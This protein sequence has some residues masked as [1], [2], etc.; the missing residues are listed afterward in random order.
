MS[1]R[2]NERTEIRQK[3]YKASV[4]ADQGRRRR[5]NITVGIRKSDRD[6]ALNEKRRRPAAEGVPQATHS[7]AVEKKLESL[8]AMVPGLYS[9]DSS[10]QLEA[11]TQFRELLSVHRCPPIDE[12]IRIGVVPRFVE[13]L[14]RDD[15]PQLQFEAAWALTNIASGTADNT[16]V[17]VEHGAVP[18]FVKLL[19]SA[20]EDVR[21]QAVWA[22]GNVA[23]D[24][25]KCRDVVLTHGA[26]LPLQ[27]QLSE[28]AKLSMLRNIA[29][30]IC[31]FCSGKPQPVFEHVKP[32]L[33]TLRQLILSQ[34]DEVLMY[35]CR[36][37][38]YL[39]DGSNDKIQAVVEAGV[40]PRLVAL[41]NHPSPMVLIPVLRTVGNI[42]TGDDAQTQCIIDHQAL[43]NLFNLLINQN[44]IFNKLVCWTI[45]K[46][47]AGTKEQI[48]AVIN[49][50]IIGPLLHLLQNVEFDVRKE[51]ACAISN[52][53]SG[54]THDQIKFLVS[55]GCIKPLCDLLNHN[56]SR[57]VSVCLE[58]L[59]NIL[60]VGE[61]ENSS[62]ACD[63]NI[64]AR[65]I[66]EADGL[67]KIFDLLNHDNVEIYD[68]AGKLVES[69]WM[70]DE[71][72][73]GPSVDLP[74]S[75]F[76]F[77]NGPPSGP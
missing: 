75:G 73:N 32:A 30:T 36:A 23:A 54:G 27:Q 2:P 72:D 77:G 17:V 49:A 22:L 8:A 67:D 68:K 31:N 56:D 21:E 76:H 26:M 24:S 42:V 60:R 9:D 74:Q 57:T 48:Q 20:N 35:S 71:D 39:S 64:F 59:E 47:T 3:G 70:Q 50:N 15:Y 41:L 69:Y 53:T 37:L 33:P 51:A 5:E 13:L 63:G 11:T 38:C 18:I 58:G 10:M 29:W 34:D 14:T 25:A 1:L 40:C 6:R 66:D 55:Q 16:R 4:D 28:H 61:A 12:V 19:S 46:I 65:M 62:G 7:P 43:P 45:S 44:K 52:A